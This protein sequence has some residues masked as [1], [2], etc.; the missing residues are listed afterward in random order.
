M[1]A[2]VVWGLKVFHHHIG[3]SLV[4]I[5]VLSIASAASE[6]RSPALGPTIAQ[7]ISVSTSRSSASRQPIGVNR[8]MSTT[9]SGVRNVA[10]SP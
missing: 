6:I 10:S 4:S 2:L 8:S 9:T 1:V 5:I 7:P 3:R